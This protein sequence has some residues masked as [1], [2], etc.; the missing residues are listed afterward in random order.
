MIQ[1]R[2]RALRVMVYAG[3]RPAHRPEALGQSAGR[4]HRPGRPQRGQAA[5]GPPAR[6]GRRRP[7]RRPCRQASPSWSTAGSSGARRSSPCHPGRPANYR[8]CIDLKIM[9]ALGALA[10]SRLDTATLDRFYAELRQRGSKCQHCYRRMRDGQPPMRPG[11][12]FRLALHRQ[13]ARPPD[14]LRAGHPD[15][16]QRHPRRP[17]RA[18]GRL[19]AGHGVGLA[20]PTTRPGW[21]PHRPSGE[22][23]GRA[24][25]G[26]ARPSGSSRRRWPRTPSWGCSWSWP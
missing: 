15:D 12:V 1:Q 25:R 9:P 14:R 23:R 21:R 10:V 24:A 16:G 20:Q 19:Q 26:S 4:R 8:R 18:V 5:R 17:R 22:G 7:H 13:G 2:G 11:E 3:P 6:R